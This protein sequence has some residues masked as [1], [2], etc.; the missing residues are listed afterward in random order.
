MVAFQI[1]NKTSLPGNHG[2]AYCNWQSETFKWLAESVK[3]QNDIIMTIVGLG[4]SLFE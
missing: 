4:L 2:L 3:D 1:R